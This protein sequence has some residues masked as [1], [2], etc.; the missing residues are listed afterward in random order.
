MQIDTVFL[1][2]ILTQAR[3]ASR[4]AG[5]IADAADRAIAI[6]ELTSTINEIVRMLVELLGEP[7]P[8]AAPVSSARQA[9]IDASLAVRTAIAHELSAVLGPHSKVMV[10]PSTCSTF[11]LAVVRRDDGDTQDDEPT[12]V[13]PCPAL[14]PRKQL[15]EGVQ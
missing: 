8:V 11:A 15:A 5:G 9:I 4:L 1:E 14:R 13:R 12:E 10:V 7:H 3:S 2:T 6:G